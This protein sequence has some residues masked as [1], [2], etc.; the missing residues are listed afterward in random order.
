MFLFCSRILSRILHCIYLLLLLSL[1][2]SVRVPRYFLVFI[3]TVLKSI[4]QLFFG[5]SLN[6]DYLFFFFNDWNEVMYFWQYRRNDVVFFPMQNI[7]WFTKC[8]L[9][10][11][12][13]LVSSEFH[14]NKVTI[15]S[16]VLKSILGKT[17]WIYANPV[18]LQIFTHQFSIHQ[19]ILTAS[20]CCGV[21]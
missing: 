8:Y 9:D 18:S 4:D 1:W 19:W 13:N 20:Y 12:V 14:H 11:L 3:L 6:S 16:F 2:Q 21:A 5:Q 10:H 15:F 17:L 7:K